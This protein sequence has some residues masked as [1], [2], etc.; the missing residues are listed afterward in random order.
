MGLFDGGSGNLGHI[1]LIEPNIGDDWTTS[2]DP[3]ISGN[4]I[5]SEMS[6]YILTSWG[7]ETDTA[8]Y[9]NISRY[10]LE[11][12][13]I[14]NSIKPYKSTGF[15][16]S[17]MLGGLSDLKT[18]NFSMLSENI[19]TYRIV[20]RKISVYITSQITGAP[21]FDTSVTKKRFGGRVEKI[22]PS[23]KNLNIECKSKHSI[24]NKD[25]EDV[26]SVESVLTFGDVKT[27]IEQN[28]DGFYV[29][30]RPIN[31]I[32]IYDENIDEY[33]NVIDDR[34]NFQDNGKSFFVNDVLKTYEDINDTTSLIKLNSEIRLVTNVLDHAWIPQP[35]PEVGEKY[36]SADGGVF[37]YRESFYINEEK[38]FIFSVN[39]NFLLSSIFAADLYMAFRLYNNATDLTDENVVGVFSLH[40]KVKIFEPEVANLEYSMLEGMKFFDSLKSSS[41]PLLTDEFE[42]S[43]KKPS[44]FIK[45]G[46]EK[47]LLLDYFDIHEDYIEFKVVRGWGN[48]VEKE[49]LAG[50]N[51]YV[52]DSE[53]NFNDIES[54]EKK[55]QL[56]NEV[57]ILVET[58]SPLSGFS[59]LYGGMVKN[60]DNEYLFSAY[61]TFQIE[62]GTINYSSWIQAIFKIPSI[63]G[64]LESVYLRGKF[65]H[66]HNYIEEWFKTGSKIWDIAFGAHLK[67]VFENERDP[68]YKRPL[69]YTWWEK[70]SPNTSTRDSTSIL[71]NRSQ[72][73]DTIKDYNLR[74]DS[75][76][77][78]GK[79][80]A[81]HAKE[82]RRDIGDHESYVE[83]YVNKGIQP[84][85]TGYEQE[86]FPCIKSGVDTLENLRNKRF[87]FYYSLFEWLNLNS[88]KLNLQWVVWTMK[89]VYLDIKF[90][91][92]EYSDFYIDY[93]GN[94]SLDS[95]FF[96]SDSNK[97]YSIDPDGT[98]T[99]KVIS[100]F[101]LSQIIF[102]SFYDTVNNRYAIKFFRKYDGSV[103][104]I[105]AS[106]IDYGNIIIDDV[107]NIIY[108]DDPNTD[109]RL[110]LF[111]N[112]LNIFFS[113]K[114]VFDTKISDRK[115]YVGNSKRK[116]LVAVFDYWTLEVIEFY[117][118]NLPNTSIYTLNRPIYHTFWELQENDIGKI[119][120]TNENVYDT[121]NNPGYVDVYE[122]N[123]TNIDSNIVLS[124]VYILSLS[125]LTAGDIDLDSLAKVR[126][127]RTGWKVRFKNKKGNKNIKEILNLLLKEA[128]LIAFENSEGKIEF[129]ELLNP[130]KTHIPATSTVEDYFNIKDGW[131][132]MNI[133]TINISHV[134]SAVKVK[135][136]YDFN[137][138]EY[139]Q[140][141]EVSFDTE[142]YLD[143]AVEEGEFKFQALQ[144]TD[145]INDVVKMNKFFH[146]H[147]YSVLTIRGNFGLLNY[148][149]G[150]WINF[151]SS[152]DPYLNS[153]NKYYW[154]VKQKEKLDG[155][156]ELVL[157][158]FEKFPEDVIQEVFIN[159][160]KW[161]ETFNLGDDIQEVFDA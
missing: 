48:T 100:V 81:L 143:G 55:E 44:K 113:D 137:S 92:A 26:G 139:K 36:Y 58:I 154:V 57:G 30:N 46:D 115:M 101:E 70:D 136:D 126:D 21:S 59:T 34:I 148:K 112:E 145:G 35:N 106:S 132:D 32:Y 157:Y 140:E 111:T 56:K 73:V 90:R 129:T 33:Y 128:G 68:Y 146:S 12:G 19:E 114:I 43:P 108:Y 98:G 83:Y 147:T 159:S 152:M 23:L 96:L 80:D 93:S 86:C 45:I 155:S 127:V 142:S 4:P 82:Y 29:A 156:V 85:V 31:N 122:K 153:T 124:I 20:G 158:E 75:I 42:T 119:G 49:H 135:Y 121:L 37:K 11:I 17:V 95:E 107:N 69:G 78:W 8:D 138:E 105:P 61:K 39:L 6:G 10:F 99:S 151:P 65:W 71:S 120:Y 79:F 14:L 116:S 110:T 38:K 88:D 16:N 104:L 84:G 22:A 63:N 149:L 91:T 60:S 15:T 18:F 64:S 41:S 87:L 150:E 109:P 3:L 52:F 40:S 67:L 117:Y 123:M 134:Y 47:I 7:Y 94:N 53:S 77:T 5:D 13:T 66:N 25:L 125:G 28:K 141:T 89:N 24:L 130:T 102:V 62:E 1:I 76:N 103:K 160:D 72:E 27:K 51:V 9:R 54:K 50:E 131:L 161:E 118:G 74:I 144:D 97:K 2:G 133:S